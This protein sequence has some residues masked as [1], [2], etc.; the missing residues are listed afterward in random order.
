MKPADQMKM[1]EANKDLTEGHSG[2]MEMS[3]T[4]LSGSL[5]TKGW[6]IMPKLE[7]NSSQAIEKEQ[8]N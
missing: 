4:A 7:K 2:Q 8:G 1:V 3:S 6:F 5:A